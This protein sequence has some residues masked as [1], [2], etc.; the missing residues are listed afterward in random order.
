MTSP[1]REHMLLTQIPTADAL[2]QA[3][4]KE[5]SSAIENSRSESQTLASFCVQ[6]RDQI[7]SLI[8]TCNREATCLTKFSTILLYKIDYN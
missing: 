2:I 4:T 3:S 6:T 7:K 5:A 1:D 8:D